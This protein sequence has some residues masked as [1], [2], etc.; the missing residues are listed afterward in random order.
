MVDISRETPDETEARLRRVICAADLK[1]YEAPYAFTEFAL[2]EFP[3]AVDPEAVAL[4][5]D[6]QV[7]SQLAPHRGD[8]SQAFTVFRFHFP[9]GEDNSGFVG[10]L[11][12]H[13]KRRFGTG[14]FVVC[15][16]N[17]ARGGVFDYWGCPLEVGR[18]VLTELDLLVR[19]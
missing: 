13:F 19:R 2:D 7:W 17:S 15:G 18:E 3:H 10:W 5:R 1:V 12:T 8:D 9:P 14:V 6:D 4:V 11:A 16:Q